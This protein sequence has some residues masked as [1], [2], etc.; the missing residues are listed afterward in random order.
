M[1]FPL[2]ELFLQS[3]LPLTHSTNSCFI[4]NGTEDKPNN[5]F[6]LIKPDREKLLFGCSTNK[7]HVSV[8]NETFPQTK[9]LSDIKHG[10]TDPIPF[11]PSPITNLKLLIRD[12]Y[13]TF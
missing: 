9:C 5:L 4:K 1:H 8:P 2:Y 12:I 6:N 11:S 13:G 7:I 10:I 3:H